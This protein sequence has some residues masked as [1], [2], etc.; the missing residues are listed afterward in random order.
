[1]AARS[2]VGR[3]RSR[4]RSRSQRT[5]RTRSE[6]P[7]RAE[8]IRGR[9]HVDRCTYVRDSAS[10]LSVSIR[11]LKGEGEKD[12]V[13]YLAHRYPG[14]WNRFDRHWLDGSCSSYW[15]LGRIRRMTGERGRCVRRVGGWRR[16]ER[17][18][19]S[20]IVDGLFVKL[21]GKKRGRKE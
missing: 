21:G 13:A 7:S 8:R 6:N 17:R 12:M 15:G 4:S 5:W 14:R 9:G 3:G 2:T 10:P 16:Y 19:M 1:M 18:R 11:A 20:R